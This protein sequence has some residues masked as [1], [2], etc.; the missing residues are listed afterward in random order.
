ME[1]SNKKFYLKGE[2]KFGYFLSIAYFLLT[3]TNNY[4]NFS[5]II[6]RDVLSYKPKVVLDIGTGP[7]VIPITISNYSKNK[8]IV[9]GLDPSK[10]MISIAKRKSRDIKNIQFRLGSSREIP[11]NKKFDVILSS[12]SLHHWK[13]KENSINYIKNFLKKNGKILIYEYNKDSK[14][15]GRKFV[16]SHALSK[17]ELIKLAKECKMKIKIKYIDTLIIGALYK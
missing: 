2:E 13:E 8:V 10:Q 6:S 15:L 12:L 9:F 11:F 4:K 7:G 3:K 5:S 16:R 1:H 14:G 17:Q